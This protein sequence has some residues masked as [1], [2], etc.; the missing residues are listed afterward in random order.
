MRSHQRDWMRFPGLRVAV[1]TTALVAVLV[2]SIPTAA[3]ASSGRRVD[4]GIT[5]DGPWTARLVGFDLDRVSGV[6]YF[7][8]DAR[9][10]WRRIASVTEVPFEAPIKWWEGDDHGAEAVTAHVDLVDGS[11]IKDPGGWRWVNG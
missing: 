11:S 8:R 10:R 3:A 9:G 5:S 4:V 1:T 7:I 6:T 2:L